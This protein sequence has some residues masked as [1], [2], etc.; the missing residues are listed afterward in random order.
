MFN[1]GDLAVRNNSLFILKEKKVENLTEQ[2]NT[3]ECNSFF[4][5]NEYK[6][7]SLL[8]FV[9]CGNTTSVSA[10]IVKQLYAKAESQIALATNCSEFIREYGAI[11]GDTN[12]FRAFQLV[13]MLKVVATR[14]ATLPE[15]MLFSEVF[16][17]QNVDLVGVNARPGDVVVVVKNTSSHGQ[18][19]GSIYTLATSTT[20]ENRRKW[21]VVNCPVWFWDA[22]L[23]L[24][25]PPFLLREDDVELFITATK[26]KMEH[27]SLILRAMDS[28]NK[29][30]FTI[31][32][33]KALESIGIANSAHQS[34]AAKLDDVAATIASPW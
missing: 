10:M 15:L 16:S 34:F 3:L 18:K 12:L 21:S 27:L 5:T 31:A 22:D 29:Q 28:S 14:K 33:I 9:R 17:P 13:K 30:E 26:K 25:E 24:I 8:D 2:W 23:K 19:I 6:K 4:P 32:H 11:N 1:R 20:T 7:P